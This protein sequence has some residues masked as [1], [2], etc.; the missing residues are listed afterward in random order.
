MKTSL[1]AAL[2]ALGPA[3][4]LAQAPTPPA[5]AHAATRLSGTVLNAAGHPLPGA[6]V[7]LRGCRV[8]ES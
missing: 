4:T 8:K 6:N 1:L 5:G 2:L 3:A 7:F